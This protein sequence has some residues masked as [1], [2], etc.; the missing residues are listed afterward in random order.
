MARRRGTRDA[1]AISNQR[2]R[3]EK[4]HYSSITPSSGRLVSLREYEDRRL[5]H[6][7][8]V[9][10]PA[11]SFSSTRHRLTSYGQT[12]KPPLRINSPRSP[13]A[14]NIGWQS[15]FS[16]VPAA[17]GFTQ[18][19]RVLICVRRAQR[20]EVLHAKRIA[21]GSGAQ[22]HPRWTVYSSIRCK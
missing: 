3:Y 15:A 7:E 20:R 13:I 21:G 2:L 8:G 22:R 6:P 11:R 19:S 5:F 10:A 18:P 4:P 1:D 17:V 14:P 9:H 16:Q 12:H